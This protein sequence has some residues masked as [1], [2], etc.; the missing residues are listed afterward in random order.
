VTFF[1]VSHYTT[2]QG[3]GCLSVSHLKILK[4]FHNIF[5]YIMLEYNF[6]KTLEKKFISFYKIGDWNIFMETN[7]MYMCTQ[8]HKYIPKTI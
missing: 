2:F 5:A 8:K 4:E 7:V 6:G 1:G 3:C